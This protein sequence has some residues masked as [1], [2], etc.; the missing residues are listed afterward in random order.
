MSD[1]ILNVSRRG[2][3]QGMVSTGALVLSVRL[4]P[5]ALW[6]AETAAGSHADRAVLHPSV[7]VG[8]DTDGTVYLVAARSEM[9]TSSRTS[10]PLILADELDADWKRVKIEQAIGDPRYGDQ[11]TDGSHSV[12]DGFVTMREAGATA[13]LMLTQ[14]AA[15]KWGVP[16]SECESDL[17]VIVHQ[18]QQAQGRLRRTGLGSRQIAR[19]QERRSDNTSRKAPGDTSAKARSATTCR[20]FAP[21]RPASA[22]TRTGWHGLCLGRA[23]SGA[24]RQG[25]VLR[26]EG[27]AAGKGREANYSDQALHPAASFSTAG[28]RRGDCRQHLGRVSGTQE[29]ERRVGQRRQCQLQL[30]SIQEGVAGDGPQTGKGRAQYRRRGCRVCQ[31]REDHGSG[32]LRAAPGARPHGTARGPGRLSRRQGNGVDS[33]RRARRRCRRRSAKNSASPRKT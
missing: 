15:Q 23:S 22:W 8:I 26:R 33:A 20:I 14:A 19:A 1:N 9:G 16:V 11:D 6:A 13:R 3:L 25:Q 30:G 32:V 29:T 10:V 24:G 12:R 17:H 2:F 7:F 31:G 18:A 5:E 28:R 4:V 27:S 21:A